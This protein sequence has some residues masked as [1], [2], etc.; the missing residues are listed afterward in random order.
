M[1]IILILGIVAAVFL[2]LGFIVSSTQKKKLRVVLGHKIDSLA[3]RIDIVDFRNKLE[4]LP[5]NVWQDYVY[6]TI[7][8]LDLIDSAREVKDYIQ[9]Y[10]EVIA[11]LTSLDPVKSKSE[12]SGIKYKLS[13]VIERANRHKFLI[14]KYGDELGNRLSN[15]QYFLGMTEEQLL[16]SKGRPD[17]VE[18]EVLKTKTKQIYI[19]GN[20]SSGDLFT[21]VNGELERFT[22]R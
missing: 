13:S 6:G 5:P 22:D 7:E 10:E 12:L 20:K 21:F 15:D 14:E 4:K 19:Y 16:D 1:S 17:K 18:T 9:N 3:T 8:R 2:T 11:K